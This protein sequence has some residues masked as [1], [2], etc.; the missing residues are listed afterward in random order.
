[1]CIVFPNGTSKVGDPVQVRVTSSFQL[2]PLL[3]GTNIPLHAEATM[4]IERPPTKYAAGC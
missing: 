3:G 4:R 2:V 1:M